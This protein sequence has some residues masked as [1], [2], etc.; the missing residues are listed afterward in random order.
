MSTRAIERLLPQQAPPTAAQ[1]LDGFRSGELSPVDAAAASLARIAETDERLHAFAYVDGERALEAARASERRWAAGEPAG[2]LDGVPV[3]IKDVDP[4]AGAP[5]RLGLLADDPRAHPAEDGSVAAA[6]LRHGAVVVGRTTTPQLGWKG[7]TDGPGREP[8]RNPHDLSRTAGGSSGGSG[9]AVAAGVV[10]L[11]TGTDGGGSIRIPA[12]AC[13]VVGIKAT[14][15]RVAQWPPSGVGALGHTGPLARTVADAALLLDVLAQPNANEAASLPP[16]ERPYRD[17]LGDGVAGLRVALSTHLGFA[18]QLD[19]DAE[20]AAVTAADALADLGAHV[21]RVDPPLGDPRALFDV[22]WQT[23]MA[24]IAAGLPA[25]WHDE[26]E[27]GLHETIARGEAH[28]AVALARAELARMELGAAM[29]RFHE[30]WD[31]LLTPAL[32]VPPF[33]AGR[34]VPDGWS[35]DGWPSWTPYTW[36]F[37]LTQQ[38]AITIPWRSTATGLPL[39]LQLVGARHR[40]RSVLRAAASLEERRGGVR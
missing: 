38:P 5:N 35:G 32:A 16:L 29:G 3:A 40:E 28:S 12:A 27:V 36:P 4:Q 18:E 21:E 34:D 26:L 33:A 22:L 2:L 39:G 1:L 20:L 15:G 30:R 9:A 24:T 17:S 25:V 19:P 8:T 10:P 23:S 14:Y 31:V 13:G 37:N 6:L 7:V 11:A